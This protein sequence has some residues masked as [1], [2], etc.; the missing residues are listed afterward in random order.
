[1]SRLCRDTG[2][3]HPIVLCSPARLLVATLPVP[4]D[5]AKPLLH[6]FHCFCVAG[7]LTDVVANLDCRSPTSGRKFNNDIQRNRLLAI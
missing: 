2:S 5:V 4:L 7:V 1:M 6:F 3:L